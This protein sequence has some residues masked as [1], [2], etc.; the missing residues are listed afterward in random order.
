MYPF[1]APLV[2]AV[3]SVDDKLCEAKEEDP[4]CSQERQRQVE[5][6]RLEALHKQ[7]ALEAARKQREMDEAEQRRWAELERRRLEE[8]QR[9]LR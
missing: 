9:R 5:V 8:E 3:S 2:F 6:L 7:Q 4:L 1:S